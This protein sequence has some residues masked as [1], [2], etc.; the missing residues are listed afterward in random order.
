MGEESTDMSAFEK[1][2]R[3]L[4]DQLNPGAGLEIRKR[5]GKLEV[6]ASNVEGL[7]CGEDIL[8]ALVVTV[9]HRVAFEKANMLELL[10]IGSLKDRAKVKEH[11]VVFDNQ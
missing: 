7:W 8:S 10:V 4:I 2:L 1:Y 3:G 9:M 6:D 5:K 11:S